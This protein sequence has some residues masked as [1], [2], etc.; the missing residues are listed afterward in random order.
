MGGEDWEAAE[1]ELIPGCRFDSSGGG[2][3]EKSVTITKPSSFFD[4][5]VI[6]ELAVFPSFP[7]SCEVNVILVFLDE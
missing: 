6:S 4:S 3:G 7:S 2:W 5:P 1:A